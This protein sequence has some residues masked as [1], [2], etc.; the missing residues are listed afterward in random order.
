MDLRRIAL[1]FLLALAGLPSF[2][3][4]LYWMIDD[5]SYSAW[6]NPSFACAMI[7][8]DGTSQYLRLSYADAPTETGLLLAATDAD[9][10]KEIDGAWAAI[11]AIYA[12][13]PQTRLVLELYALDSASPARSS[14]FSLEM[15]N[16]SIVSTIPSQRESFPAAFSA[17]NV[18]PEPTSGLL[19]L[20]GMALL[21][22]KRKRAC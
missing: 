20:F 14:A 10:G 18:V 3:D 15:L 11:D 13:D 19:T 12:E 16:E 4:Y 9:P 2:G 22:L 8:V 21:A 17:W 6:E 5:G 7:R 1:G